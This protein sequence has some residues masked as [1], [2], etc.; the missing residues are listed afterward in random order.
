MIAMSRKYLKYDQNQTYI[1]PPNPRE[2]LPE[3]HLAF[4]IS[5]IVDGL[6]LSEIYDYYDQAEAGAPPYNPEMLINILFYAYCIGT[7]SSR[8]IRAK[9]DDD[10]AF[11]VL[12]AGNFPD[13]RTISDFRKI[14]LRVLGKLFVQV[15]KVCETEGLIDSGIVAFDGTK[16]KGNASLSKNRTKKELQKESDELEKEV[17][18]ILSEA[19]QIDN[20]EDNKYGK[21]NRGDELP[22]ELRRKEERQKRIK[23]ALKQITEKEEKEFEEYNRK[24]EEKKQKEA[25]TGKKASGRKLKSPDEKKK[26]LKRN[27]TDPDSRIMKT[28][29]GHIQGYNAQAAVDVKTQVILAAHVTQDANDVH[30]GLP[31]FIEVIQN[32]G[33]IP[34][35]SDFDAGYWSEDELKLI[36]QYT[37]LYIP[38]TKDWK[39]RKQLREQGAPKGRRPANMNL[40]EQMERK[41]LTK[42]GQKIYAYRK[43]SIEPTFGQIKDGRGIDKFMLRGTEKVNDEWNLICMTHNILKLFRN[44][45]KNT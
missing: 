12:C 19:E 4:F 36:M 10:V 30:Q 29:K 25:Q 39:R 44:R 2:W 23:D 22:K 6:D 18:K 14:H 20:E 9:L 11:R 27:I 13:F 38:T 40:R 35:K 15:L 5:E 21:E 37:D 41:L 43:K 7:R 34:E 3:G 45:S 24:L 33:R 1:L 42:H 26:E 8:K 28:Q 17:K 32:L 31:M 16:M